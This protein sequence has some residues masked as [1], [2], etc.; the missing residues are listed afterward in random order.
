MT[1][2]VKS[3]A[4]ENVSIEETEQ[5][6]V[7]LVKCHPCNINLYDVIDINME[8][9]DREYIE[10]AKKLIKHYVR[11]RNRDLV[12]KVKALFLSA[13]GKLYCEICDFSFT[14]TYGKIGEGFIEAHHI[15][16]ISTAKENAAVKLEDMCLV[17]ANCHR[18]L[19]RKKPTDGEYL[20][21]DELRSIIT[22]RIP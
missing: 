8:N 2:Q 11:E 4:L 21:I 6:F 19:H 20:S 15:V 10:G 7:Y 14:D 3:P 17:C 22:R 1:R 18:M 9:R 13:H 5:P 12:K 16:P